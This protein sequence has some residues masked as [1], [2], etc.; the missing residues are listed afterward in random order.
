MKSLAVDIPMI[1][2]TF[3]EPSAVVTAC[4]GSTWDV[5]TP[6]GAKQ[7]LEADPAR[8]VELRPDQIRAMTWDE[9]QEARLIRH[10]G[11]S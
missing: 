9:R 7:P 6:H 10:R 8:S 1:R 5:W 2:G 4:T 3:E 11:S